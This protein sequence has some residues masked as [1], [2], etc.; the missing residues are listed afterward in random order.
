MIEENGFFTF[1][2]LKCYR[3]SLFIHIFTLDAKVNSVWA[4]IKLAS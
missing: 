3:K 4:T 1:L 2:S